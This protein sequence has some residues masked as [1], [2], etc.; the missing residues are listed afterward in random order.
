MNTNLKTQNQKTSFL[1]ALSLGSELGFLIVLPLVGF[2]I[3][4]VFL[5]KKFQ[6]SP[7]FVIVFL[8][9]SFISVALE[10]RYLIMP[11]LEK[12]SSNN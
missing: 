9:L 11:F 10:T 5:D 4:G 2:L 3:L 8:I 1:K 6:T 12:R 7:I